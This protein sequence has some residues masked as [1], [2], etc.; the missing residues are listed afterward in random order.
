GKTL[1]TLPNPAPGGGGPPPTVTLDGGAIRIRQEG[2]PEFAISGIQM[3]MTPQGDKL[4][5]S[6]S[7][8]DPGW[9]A[10][11]VSGE[12]DRPNKTGWVE[13]ATDDGPLVTERLRSVPYVP[14]SIWDHVR[15]DGRGGMKVRLAYAPDGDGK[16][17]NELRPHGTTLGLP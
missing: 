9:G 11:R 10:W 1:P 13:L 8:D 2:K 4:V 12:I 6:G 5:I 15:P 16:D 7:V 17:D 14:G 3:R